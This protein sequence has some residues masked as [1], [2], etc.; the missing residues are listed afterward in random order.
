MVF[1]KL[2]TVIIILTLLFASSSCG[3][4]NTDQRINQSSQN[5]IKKTEQ[6]SSLTI[7]IYR[8]IDKC[9]ENAIEQFNSEGNG[10]IKAKIFE[11]NSYMELG[12]QL[13]TELASGIGPDLI[14]S[15]YY[16]LSHLVKL[17][18]NGSFCNLDELIKEDNEFNFDDYN[19][20]AMN[21]GIVDGSRFIMPLSYIIY[22]VLY[23]T[24]QIVE[25]NKFSIKG[26]YISSA[27]L[28]DMARELTNKNTGTETYLLDTFSLPFCDSTIELSYNDVDID[29]TG[30]IQ[31]FE[32]FKEIR[33][34]TFY[35]PDQTIITNN[36]YYSLLPNS[37]TKFIF[38]GIIN[39]DYLPQTYRNFQSEFTPEIYA[40]A[41]PNEENTAIMQ[42]LLLAAINDN[43][44][45]KK[46]AFEFIKIMMSEEIQ[47]KFANGIPVNKVA[48]EYQKKAFIDNPNKYVKIDGKTAEILVHQADE[49]I[50]GDLVFSSM[51]F[52]ENSIISEEAIAVYS[53]TK[54]PEEAAKSSK[55]RISD[56]LNGDIN[57][58]V[59]EATS[60][61]D[62]PT[63][64]IEYMD[65]D[66]AIRNAVKAFNEERKDIRIEETIYPSSSRDEFVNKLITSVMAGERPDIIYYDRYMFNSLDKTVSTGVFSDLN[67]LIGNDETF[68]KLDLNDKVLESGVFNGKR[69][70]IPLRY[71][72]PLLMTTKGILDQ[73]GIN[74]DESNWTFDEFKKKLLS[75]VST[76]GNK[77]FINSNILFKFLV[78][79]CGIDLVNYETKTANF[80]SKD[81]I[82]IM[83][84]YKDIYPYITPAEIDMDYEFP[85]TMI[86]N[87]TIA[88]NFSFIHSPERLWS[89]NSTYLG[90]LGEEPVIYPLPTVNQSSSIPI[91]FMNAVSINQNCKNKQAALDFIEELLSENIQNATDKNGN[92]NISLGFPVNNKALQAELKSYMDPSTTGKDLSSSTQ[93]F[94]SMP[95]SEELFLRITELC[96]RTCAGP[97]I[98]NVVYGIINEGLRSYLDGKQS[99]EEAAKDINNKVNLFLNE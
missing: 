22:G 58:Y 62:I 26:R 21:Y 73:N 97:E 19:D 87:H 49:I 13:E 90:I 24:N 94:T 78:N 15:Q 45:N 70:Y 32:Q 61:S 7:Y 29:P 9:T 17:I 96:S 67:E 47:K 56:Y 95:L 85:E 39:M 88:M 81:F 57:D 77:Y 4:Q 63:L 76:S 40:V 20:K 65:T 31:Y 54:T 79:G 50:N 82:D 60:P 83:E 59:H 27:N 42:P 2:I 25:E 71:E 48:Y 18:Q 89:D 11:Y 37:K 28:E 74:I 72:L 34:L 64:T 46:A 93:S 84:F 10:F 3:D 68:K 98:D 80:Q 92:S 33:N 35:T 75:Y 99:A 86:Q 51:D 30:V 38:D 23:S 44:R 6:D 16:D 69:Y 52:A 66:N 43:C 36:E 55:V 91:E 1:K 41:P 12:K 53:G 5:S 14:V 8:N